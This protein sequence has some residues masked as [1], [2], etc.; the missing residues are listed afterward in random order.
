MIKEGNE[1]VGVGRAASGCPIAPGS[2][3]TGTKGPGASS[4]WKGPSCRNEQLKQ[5]GRVYGEHLLKDQPYGHPPPPPSSPTHVQGSPRGPL[6][7]LSICS[8]LQGCDSRGPFQL[9]LQRQVRGRLILQREHDTARG[10]QWPL[11][12][13]VVPSPEEDTPAVPMGYTEQQ[14]QV[15]LSKQLTSRD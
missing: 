2:G 15:T 4:R 12:L 6:L 14:S 13:E 11:L 1:G 9:P 8:P 3:D 10:G 5:E 7:L